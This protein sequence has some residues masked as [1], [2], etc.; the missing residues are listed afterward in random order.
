MPGPL[1]DYAPVGGMPDPLQ[2]YARGPDPAA[3][4]MTG[5]RPY[6]ARMPDE[7]NA[8]PTPLGDMARNWLLS[9]GA[10]RTT[11]DRVAGVIPFTGAE[12]A[13]TG[14]D[15][16]A[17]GAAR[18]NPALF[19][20]GLGN[21]GLAALPFTAAPRAGLM[22]RIAEVP[23][24]PTRE[25]LPSDFTLHRFP[26][27]ESAGPMQGRM[28]VGANWAVSHPDI[29]GMVSGYFNPSTRTLYMAGSH[30]NS[31]LQG[32]G[33]GL[34]MYRRMIDEAHRLGYRVFS[35]YNVSPEAQRIYGALADP[36][37]GYRVIREPGASLD[38]GGGLH[39]PSGSLGGVFEVLPPE[40]LR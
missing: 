26:D 1:D 22:S 23:R 16:L 37:R 19:G 34:A 13:R 9:I 18:R 2:Q 8:R 21:I 4:S 31:N 40:P 14:G 32:Q 29:N 36:S 15:L 24:A 17:E 33:I 3:D 5:A 27:W 25:W 7:L 20:M 30:L 6:L 12:E 35:D 10:P 38:E 39:S 28:A 11:A